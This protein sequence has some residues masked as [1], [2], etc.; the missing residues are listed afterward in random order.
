MERHA[1]PEA[2][3]STDGSFSAQLIERD[4]ACLKNNATGVLDISTV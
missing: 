1:V 3:D 4:V 2:G